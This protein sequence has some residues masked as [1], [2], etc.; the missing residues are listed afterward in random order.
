MIKNDD[1]KQWMLPFSEY[2]N[3][4]L[5]IKNDWEHRDFR[6]MDRSLVLYKDK[7]LH[8]PY[9]QRY[10]EQLLLELLKAQR[11]V[12]DTGPAHVR[13]I[14]MISQE[15]LDEIRR[16]WVKEKH[17]FEDSLPRIYKEA[18]GRE[19]PKSAF[20]EGQTISPEDIEVLKHVSASPKDPD[21]LHFQLVRELLHIEQKY[22]TASRRAGVYEAFEKTLEGSAFESEQEA[23]EFAHERA[24]LRDGDMTTTDPELS[25]ETVESTGEEDLFP[26]VSQ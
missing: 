18:T 10:R 11:K 22:R 9:K 8:G 17:E 6:R 4:F 26:E 21:E 2:R 23:L 20:D 7:L 1:E 14:E 13:N 24:R 15:E 5:D 3:N 25:L 19:Y 12:Q 16:I